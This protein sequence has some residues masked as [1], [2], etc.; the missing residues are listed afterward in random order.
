MWWPR[1]PASTSSPI[2]ASLP[3]G[4]R[5]NPTTSSS[6]T[7]AAVPDNDPHHGTYYA[8]LTLKGCIIEVFGDAGT[9]ETGRYRVA[10]VETTRPLRLLDVKGDG[11]WKAGSVAALVK[12]AD[13]ALSQ[14][15][16][17]LF[18]ADARYGL[19]DGISYGNAHDDDQ[20]YVR[21]ERAGP[22]TVVTTCELADPRLEA[23]VIEIALALH[24]ALDLTKP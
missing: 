9:I 21:F 20:A 2:R 11:A 19:V 13:R 4:Q 17:R 6:S 24:L 10:I 23:E 15:W 3:A 16:A 1:V 5:K 18:Y 12:T 14:G 22:P 7:P 8:A